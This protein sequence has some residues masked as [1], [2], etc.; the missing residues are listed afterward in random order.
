MSCWVRCQLIGSLSES[1]TKTWMVR[2]VITTITKAIVLPV[3][4]SSEEQHLEH[5]FG[6]HCVTSLDGDSKDADI[7]KN[8]SRMARSALKG[9]NCRPDSRA[10]TAFN[11]NM[12]V[13][14]HHR[15]TRGS[16]SAVAREAVL[17]QPGGYRVYGTGAKTRPVTGDDHPMLDDRMSSSK[18]QTDIST[19]EQRWAIAK[20]IQAPTRT[21]VTG[22]AGEY[23]KENFLLE[24]V[25]A[26]SFTD[27][28]GCG[29]WGLQVTAFQ[30]WTE[31]SPPSAV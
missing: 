9:G 30:P 17:V 2:A 29:C 18:S 8:G 13:R 12:R 5:D 20:L 16:F 28:L 25:Q 22:G 24:P 19:A 27:P 6:P 1:D 14:G 31:T 11:K 10:A 15:R 26:L 7:A 4:K 21:P 3:A 23:T